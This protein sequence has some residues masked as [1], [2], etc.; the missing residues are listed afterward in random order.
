VLRLSPRSNQRVLC[1]HNI[2]NQVQTVRLDWQSL[3]KPAPI[4]LVDILSGRSFDL[5]PNDPWIMQPY[6]VNWLERT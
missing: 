2:S 3:F 5:K 6:Q 4:K 1:L